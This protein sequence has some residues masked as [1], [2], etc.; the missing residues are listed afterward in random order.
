MPHSNKN[1][2]LKKN[3]VINNL[4][5]KKIAFILITLFINSFSKKKLNSISTVSRSFQIL[6][7]VL[8]HIHEILLL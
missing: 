1:L 7:D 8:K 2:I 6:G 5:E 4:A 3:E